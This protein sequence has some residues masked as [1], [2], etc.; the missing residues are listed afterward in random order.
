MRRWFDR[1]RFSC[2]LK[3][4]FG[5][6]LAAVFVIGHASAETYP[7]RPI[8][9]IVPFLAGSATDVTARLLAQSLG[10]RLHITIIVENR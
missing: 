3:G 2:L 6:F 4:L 9:L 5:V 10:E 8:K 7:S 1:R